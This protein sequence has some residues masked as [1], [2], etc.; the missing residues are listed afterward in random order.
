MREHPGTEQCLHDLPSRSMLIGI[1][2]SFDLDAGF[3]ELL[4]IIGEPLRT[5][6]IVRQEEKG[7]K[8]AEDR[9]QAFDDELEAC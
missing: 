8:S 9:D 5:R 7:Q 6:G 3:D 2:S 4:V 1:S